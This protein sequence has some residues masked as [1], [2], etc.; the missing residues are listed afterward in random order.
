M[1]DFSVNIP[2]DTIEIKDN[3]S[4][5]RMEPSESDDLVINFAIEYKDLLI[6]KQSYRTSKGISCSRSSREYRLSKR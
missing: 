5:I 1:T 4:F 2:K 6:K 3:D